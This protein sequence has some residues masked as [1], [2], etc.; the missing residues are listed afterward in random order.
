MW[1]QAKQIIQVKINGKMQ[2]YY[3]SDCFEIPNQNEAMKYL[4][5]GKAQIPEL[6]R[7]FMQINFDEEGIGIISPRDIKIP[8]GIP[9]N[10]SD[11][12]EPAFAKTV[13]VNSGNNFNKLPQVVR[14]VGKLAT[15]FQLLKTYEMVL[16]LRAFKENARH[17]AKEEHERTLAI[18]GDLRVKVYSDKVWAMQDTKATRKFCKVLQEEMEYG[19]ELAMLRAFY[20]VKPIAYFVNTN[21]IK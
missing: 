9:F 12:I 13:Y 11:I 7:E 4:R 8:Y 6:L 14:N 3:P 20:Q 10:Q 5:D 2:T 21:W 19:Q 15:V 16:F 17:F 18:V 1:L